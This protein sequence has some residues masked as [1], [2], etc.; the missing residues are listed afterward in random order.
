MIDS[1]ITLKKIEIFLAFMQLENISRTADN[2]G[3]SSVSVHRALHSLEAALRCPLFIHKGRSL[4]PLPAAYTLAQW[5]KEILSLTEKAIDATRYT[6][7]IGLQHMKI[8]TLYSLTLKT[9]PRLIMGMK[10]RR[11]DT[12]LNLTMGS[13]Q[14]LLYSLEQQELDAILIAMPDQGIDHHCFETVTLFEDTIF[15]AAPVSAT[16]PGP[17]PV[18][19]QYYRAQKFVSLTDGFASTQ[20]FREAFRVAGFEPE[21][22]TQVNDIFSMLSLVQAG[23]GYALI[24]GRMRQVYAQNVQLLP[25]CEH[26]QLHQTLV[27]VFNRNREQD[28]D[29][30]A[31]I[32]ES[33]MYAHSLSQTQCICD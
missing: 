11:P 14:Q 15:L 8:G 28:P 18:D 30:L 24:P 33:R 26:Y 19:L 6:A 23:V 3:I 5:A 4:R 10:I 32:A 20:G 22:V 21:I 29:L 31:L 25:L 7:G 17:L 16:L 2:L 27:L 9:I 12:E 1:D 13:N